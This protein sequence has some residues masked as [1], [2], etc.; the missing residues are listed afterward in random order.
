[1][2]HLVGDL[3]E[4]YDDARTYKLKIGNIH[5]LLCMF[6]LEWSDIS[7]FVT[8]NFQLCFCS[9]LIMYINVY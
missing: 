6:Y 5:L 2:L 9:V 3:F 8:S 1:L 4:L 7:C